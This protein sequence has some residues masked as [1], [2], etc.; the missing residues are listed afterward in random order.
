MSINSVSMAN[1]Q[2]KLQHL[3]LTYMKRAQPDHVPPVYTP[4]K[5]MTSVVSG[6]ENSSTPL[7]GTARLM[8][9]EMVYNWTDGATFSNGEIVQPEATAEPAPHAGSRAQIPITSDSNSRQPLP[10]RSPKSSFTAISIRESDSHH[11]IRQSATREDRLDQAPRPGGGMDKGSYRRAASMF[12]DSNTPNTFPRAA[13]QMTAPQQESA[14]LEGLDLSHRASLA[15]AEITDNDFWLREGRARSYQPVVPPRD[16][17]DLRVLSEIPARWLMSSAT[18]SPGHVP[19]KREQANNVTLGQARPSMSHVVAAGG[20][21]ATR[22]RNPSGPMDTLDPQSQAQPSFT[23]AA[24]SKF[25]DRQNVDTRSSRP[26]GTWDPRSQIQPSFAN[27]ASSNFD[28]R[29]NVDIRPPTWQIAAGPSVKAPVRLFHRPS[30]AAQLAE[31]KQGLAQTLDSIQFMATSP[32]VDAPQGVSTVTR[33]AEPVYK[34]LPARNTSR[35]AEN[36]ALFEYPPPT[37]AAAGFANDTRPL[38]SND[39][40]ERSLSERSKTG[41]D[42]ATP[43]RSSLQ[44]Q[45]FPTATGRPSHIMQSPE[46]LNRIPNGA[47]RPAR[48]SAVEDMARQSPERLNRITNGAPR[49]A[50]A[51]AVQE[52]TVQKRRGDARTGTSQS[53][54]VVSGQVPAAGIRARQSAVLTNLRALPALNERPPNQRAGKD[55]SVSSLAPQRP[56]ERATGQA[57]TSIVDRLGRTLSQ[58]E[59]DLASLS[60]RF[61]SMSG[62]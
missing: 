29:Q 30:V 12:V 44:G 21:D 53:F 3:E 24:L 40:P 18:S 28:D 5:P 26:M 11:D 38:L 16:A 4:T 47:P 23:N 37:N 19:T 43:A 55:E 60:R 27:A 25:D 41:N 34:S 8:Q 62:C 14:P 17:E 54:A 46:R 1:L 57:R 52:M 22:G 49:P 13:H 42:Q 45:Q 32:Q 15:S 9:R 36:N 6:L 48:A 33:L 10:Y 59:D 61:G 20:P 50:R 31:A 51:S 56:A 2:A 39:T 7:L 35:R 58:V